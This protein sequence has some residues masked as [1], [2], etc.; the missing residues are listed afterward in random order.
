ML[1]L[2]VTVL[3]ILLVA[4][5]VI[6]VI[7]LIPL[8]APWGMVARAVVALIVLIWLIETLLGS[9]GLALAR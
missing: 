5:F 2:L 9:G 1:S 4:G 7:G 3:I 6:W 8:P